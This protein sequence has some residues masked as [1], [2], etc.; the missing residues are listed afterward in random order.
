VEFHRANLMAKLG[1]PSPTD[2]LIRA[3]KLGLG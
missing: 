3:K 2:L 1:S